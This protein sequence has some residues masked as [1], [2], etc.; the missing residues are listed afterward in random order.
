MEGVV[1]A[2]N[3]AGFGDGLVEQVCKRRRRDCCCHLVLLPAVREKANGA[4]LKSQEPLTNL[5]LVLRPGAFA[6][7]QRASVPIFALHHLQILP[8]SQAIYTYVYC[9]GIDART[10]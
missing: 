7:Y 9:Q 10:P 8:H 3:D 5:G 2:R 6:C 4:A 1:G